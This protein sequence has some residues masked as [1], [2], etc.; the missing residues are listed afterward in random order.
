MTNNTL[1]EKKHHYMF[2]LKELTVLKNQT[3]YE[4]LNEGLPKARL[5]EVCDIYT[6]VIV[7]LLEEDVPYEYVK[8]S[9][10]SKKDVLKFYI[11]GNT[12]ECKNIDVRE[13]LEDRYAEVMERKYTGPSFREI[14]KTREKNGE[15]NPVNISTNSSNTSDEVKELL[16]GIKDAIAE[17]KNDKRGNADDNNEEAQKIINDMKALIPPKIYLSPD[18]EKNEEERN[19]SKK[20]KNRK[21]FVINIIIFVIIAGL[22]IFAIKQSAFLMA[23]IDEGMRTVKSNISKTIDQPETLPLNNEEL[24]VAY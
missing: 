10:D 22:G 23:R 17:S 21:S 5:K 18:D 2:V 8:D 12:Y 7:E 11:D 16:T 13:I 24:P 14:Q 20:K 6:R 3:E 4:V 9:S 19:K 15:C 1:Y